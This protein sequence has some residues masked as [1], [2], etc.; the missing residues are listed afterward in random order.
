MLPLFYGAFIESD[1][2]DQFLDLFLDLLS[3][4][5]F[6]LSNQFKTSNT[7]QSNRST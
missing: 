4:L 7:D 2:L 1:T 5:V 3:I 6:R